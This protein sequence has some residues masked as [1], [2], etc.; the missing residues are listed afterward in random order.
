MTM[1]MTMTM[2]L[3]MIMVLVILPK[4]FPNRFSQIGDTPVLTH[5]RWEMVFLL[6][7]TGQSI[8]V[9]IVGIVGI[10]FYI[11]F[12]TYLFLWVH[13]LPQSCKYR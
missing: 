9:M 13:H 8:R 11:H 5:T 2:V 6:W 10:R 12:H 3:V 1:V 7:P 4:L